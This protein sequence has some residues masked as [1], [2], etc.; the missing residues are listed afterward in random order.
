MV[1]PSGAAQDKTALLYKIAELIGDRITKDY[2][3][4]SFEE[5]IPLNTLSNKL[6]NEVVITDVDLSWNEN[7]LSWY[8]TSKI[9]LSHVQRIDINAEM[10]GFL[11][12]RKDFEGDVINLFLQITPDTWY[13]FNYEGTSLL[14]FSSNPAYND[15]ISSKSNSAKAKLGE[16]VFAPGSLEETESFVNRYR[17]LYYGIE[18]I[19]YLE[20]RQGDIEAFAEPEPSSEQSDLGLP[21]TKKKKKKGKKAKPGFDPFGTPEEEEEEEDDDKEGF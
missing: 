12:I 17:S 19:I 20:M 5:Y 9:G 2:E 8:N 3:E 4:R 11:E 16:F 15:I 18:D 6:V 1:N 7:Y 21:S 14:T 13:Y 10:D